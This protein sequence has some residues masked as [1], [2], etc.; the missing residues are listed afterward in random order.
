MLWHWFCY[1]AENLS[2]STYKL[3][4]LLLSTDYVK[5][6]IETLKQ[7][8]CS[9]NKHNLLEIPYLALPSFCFCNV[10]HIQK[11]ILI[12]LD[13][14]VWLD[15]LLINK[16]NI[17]VDKTLYNTHFIISFTRFRPRGKENTEVWISQNKGK[18]SEN[19][20]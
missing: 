16:Y 9:K 2:Y 13:D 15:V 17:K 8:P 1:T 4:L 12:R 18:E 7:V 14:H 11:P 19:S 6:N 10:I 20:Y 5:L 3:L